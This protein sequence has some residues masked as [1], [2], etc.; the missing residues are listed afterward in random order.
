MIAISNPPEDKAA[1][2]RYAQL[3][4][5]LQRL[6]EDEMQNLEEKEQMIMRDGKF[7]TMM[8]QQ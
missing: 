8:Q 2:F 6:E 4:L 3:A 5:L 1:I 7:V